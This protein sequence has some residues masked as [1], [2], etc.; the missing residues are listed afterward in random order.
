VYQVG[1]DLL[2]YYDARSTKHQVFKCNYCFRRSFLMLVGVETKIM[3]GHFLQREI[4]PRIGLISE[5]F[6]G[7]C[8]GTFRDLLNTTAPVGLG[9]GFVRWKG[10]WGR[11]E[12]SWW[13]FGG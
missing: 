10:D 7:D 6:G 8:F 4:S 9:R 2:M 1:V 13:W 5:Q 3:H 12:G 11:G